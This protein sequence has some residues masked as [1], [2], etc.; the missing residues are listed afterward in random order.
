MSTILYAFIHPL[1]RD[2]DQPDAEQLA[3]DLEHDYKETGVEMI[4]VCPKQPIEK[5]CRSWTHVSTFLTA[6]CHI[7]CVCIQSGC[8]FQAT[9][10]PLDHIFH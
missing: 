1:C 9:N 7:D 8:I 5:L 6:I 3:Y 10:S 2:A 4:V